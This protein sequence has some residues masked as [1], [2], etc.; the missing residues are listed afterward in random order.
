VKYRRVFLLRGSAFIPLSDL[1]TIITAHFRTELSES[2]SRAYMALG[3]MKSK[4]VTI[5]PLLNMLSSLNSDGDY[6]V[7]TTKRSGKVQLSE[8]EMVG[9]IYSAHSRNKIIQAR[10][11]V[12]SNVYEKF[13]LEIKRKTSSQTHGQNAI[14]FVSKGNRT[15]IRRCSSILA[16]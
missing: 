5:T 8:I 15:L 9:S 7:D 4:L 6:K 3:T 14:R 1:P 11:T 13:T 10:Q 16:K 2:L 12:V